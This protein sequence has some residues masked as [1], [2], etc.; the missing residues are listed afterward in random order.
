[1]TNR[2]ER[3]IEDGEHELYMLVA[4]EERSTAGSVSVWPRPP[5]VAWRSSPRSPPR[6]FESKSTPRCPRR[7]W[8]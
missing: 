1:M 2:I 7:R 4:D 5:I 8:R 3:L 6:T